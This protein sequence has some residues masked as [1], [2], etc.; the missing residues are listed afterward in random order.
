MTEAF[1]LSL[2]LRHPDID[3]ETITHRVGLTPNRSWKA[4]ETRQTARGGELKGT[5]DSTYWSATLLTPP[6]SSDGE[7]A[8]AIALE[9]WISKL[10]EQ[11]TFLRTVQAGG[12]AVEL[13]VG[14]FRPQGTT[15][16]SD[17]LG[18]IVGLCISLAI[19]VY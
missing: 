11:A 8:L 18:R 15:I 17:L 13:F 7:D 16:H 5:Y 3:P 1:K 2:R 6:E 12:G 14:C 4:G 10:E 19:E 9:H